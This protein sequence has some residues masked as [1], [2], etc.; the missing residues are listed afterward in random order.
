MSCLLL[1]GSAYRLD[2]RMQQAV[3]ALER[4]RHIA[5]RHDNPS[6]AA[7]AAFEAG[8]AERSRGDEARAGEHFEAAVADWAGRQPDGLLL[9]ALS[10]LAESR[11][12]TGDRAGARALLRRIEKLRTTSGVELDRSQRARQGIFVGLTAYALKDLNRA[13][14]ALAEVVAVGGLASAGHRRLALAVLAQIALALGRNRAALLLMSGA[15]AVSSAPAS[16]HDDA[17]SRYLRALAWVRLN[18]PS[19][20]LR[21]LQAEVPWED[22]ESDDARTL[23]LRAKMDQLAASL[24][25]QTGD[26]EAEVSPFVTF[27]VR[28]VAAFGT[29]LGAIRFALH[30]LGRARADRVV[31]GLD[32]ART[33]AITDASGRVLGAEGVRQFELGV[34]ALSAGNHKRA[35][36]ALTFA[37]AEF[38]RHPELQELQ[39]G[40]MV[41]LARAYQ[42]AENTPRRWETLQ[43]AR[44]IADAMDPAI[45][46]SDV[47]YAQIY[48]DLGRMLVGLPLRFEEAEFLFRSALDALP[49]DAPLGLRVDRLMHVG[50]MAVENGRNAYAIGKLSEALRL[51]RRRGPALSEYEFAAAAERLGLAYLRRG[52][53]RRA[54]DHFELALDVDTWKA[55]QGRAL[56]GLGA[57]AIDCGLPEVGLRYAEAALELLPGDSSRYAR[58][59]VYGYMAQAHHQLRDVRSVREAATAGLAAIDGDEAPRARIVRTRLE[60]ADAMYIT[61]GVREVP[62]AGFLQRSR[63]DPPRKIE[64]SAGL[65]RQMRRVATAVLPLVV[66]WRR[67]RAPRV[68][69]RLA[70]APHLSRWSGATTSEKPSVHG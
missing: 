27:A 33:S 47:L 8:E 31:L 30:R 15:D 48:H 7:M 11:L 55:T 5:A 60:W 32:P 9:H 19:K 18:E 46:R 37:V 13:A 12:A 56:A 68:R 49:P 34:A 59:L 69:A 22:A 38:E 21:D 40:A 28:H 6:F 52:A 44:E 29:R 66:A 17:S 42:A 39:V 63:D 51:H 43:R 50:E 3:D 16:A 4:C 62:A 67:M 45:R 65:A 70:G 23:R 14:P 53:T 25:A 57:L 24:R 58:A 1:L 61:E 64:L 54:L 2:G 10:H 36:A 35:V 20:A 26:P 41:S